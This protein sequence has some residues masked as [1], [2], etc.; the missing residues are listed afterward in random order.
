MQWPAG[1]KTNTPI[2]NLPQFGPPNLLRGARCL[3]GIFRKRCQTERH[4]RIFV[5]FV[6]KKTTNLFLIGLSPATW[7]TLRTVGKSPMEDIPSTKSMRRRIIPKT[8]NSKFYPY[9]LIAGNPP[10]NNEKGG[11]GWV[12][13]PAGPKTNTPIANLP[14]IWPSQPI[15]RGSLSKGSSVDQ[16]RRHF[17]DVPRLYAKNRK[18]LQPKF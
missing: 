17:R 13:W 15:K 16:G 2:A 9:Y 14:L 1:P 12:Q 7:T 8:K 5:S 4:A 10:K 11:G 3:R 18:A 6:W